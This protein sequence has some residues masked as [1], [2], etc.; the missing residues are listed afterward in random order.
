[1]PGRSLLRRSLHYVIFN[2]SW[3]RVV[4]NEIDQFLRI[5]EPGR[6]DRDVEKYLDYLE[7]SLESFRRHHDVASY[8]V[9]LHLVC[10]SP[11]GL[12]AAVLRDRLSSRLPALRV[13]V[14]EVD[15][16][17]TTPFLSHAASFPVEVY[18]S[19]NQLHETVLLSAVEQSESDVAAFVDPDVTFIRDGALDQIGDQLWRAEDQWAAGFIEPARPRRSSRG[20][21]LTRERLHSVAVFF[22]PDVIRANLPATGSIPPADMESRLAAVRDP[23]AVAHY[24]YYRVTDT[25]SILTELLRSSY[26]IDRLLSLG[27]C[28]PRYAEGQMLTIVCDHLVHCKYQDPTARPALLEALALAGIRPCE[29]PELSRLVGMAST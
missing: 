2:D 18:R 28:L 17:V 1:M 11:D 27:R 10:V 16:A 26:G 19:P 8:R 3:D 22:K 21:F 7:H 29:S 20:A 12:T 5:P 14:D 25:F 24:M 15:A 6:F 23:E 13:E 4:G 9:C